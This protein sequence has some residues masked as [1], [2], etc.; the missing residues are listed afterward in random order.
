MALR[1]VVRAAC[2]LLLCFL[3][4]D[5]SDCLATRFLKRSSYPSSS[6]LFASEEC[7]NEHSLGRRQFGAV[8]SQ[9]IAFSTV[10]AS[11]DQVLAKG[12]EAEDKSKL[13]KGYQRLT[14]LLD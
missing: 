12:T 4:I 6:L 2:T 11:S 14:Y 3:F 10:F 9:S 8:I 5:D 13:L 7:R 1:E